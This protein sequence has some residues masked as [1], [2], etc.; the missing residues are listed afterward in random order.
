MTV[1]ESIA[2]QATVSQAEALFREARR[3]RRRR[4]L[5]LGITAVLIS[6]S[7]AGMALS[8][9]TTAQSHHAGGPPAASPKRAGNGPR[10]VPA[11]AET[12]ILSVAG[13]GQEFVENFSGVYST[14]NGGRNWRNITPP[15]LA[16][17]PVLLVHVDGVCSFGAERVWLLVSA[18]ADFGIQLVYTWNGG[19]TW[20]LTPS[21][22]D[23]GGLPS[24]LP[25]G[26]AVSPPDFMTAEDGWDLATS[27][28]ARTEELYRTN[29]GGAHWTFV[30]D[31]PVTGSVEFTNSD[32]GWG[33]TE[34]IPND[35]GGVRTPGGALYRT[36]DGGTTW[37]RV[38]LP[39]IGNGNRDPVTYDLPA[40]FSSDV[41]IVAGRL[42]VPG[43]GRE[44]V[45]VDVTYDGGA[46][47]SQ[48]SIPPSAATRGYQQGFFT[49]PFSASSVTDW[50]VF[51]GSVLLTTS[52]GGRTWSVIH[53]KLPAVAP[54][55]DTLYADLGNKI[56]ALAIRRE[57]ES[58]SQY[59]IVTTNGGRT[60]R[61]VSP[62]AASA[63]GPC[64]R[65]SRGRA[66]QGNAR[67]IALLSP[68]GNQRI[69]GRRP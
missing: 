8:N 18:D 16:E 66:V 52:D 38:R 28:R 48:R 23:D 31:T 44:P 57:R 47:W 21:I 53:P 62:Q 17:N 19:T 37:Q 29:D 11:P 7:V 26:A 32:D 43:N 55:V 2:D 68:T 50:S 41:G 60:W 54:T 6:A 35:Q 34:W 24:F 12:Q 15:I 5:V 69:L 33:I 27:G 9:G 58:S 49:V 63:G 1:I 10:V 46:S 64:I 45:V 61:A 3:R 39:A 36:V 51:E 59:L 13:P 22:S 30:S 40:F 4:R 56:W 42:D 20:N 25:D 65:Q 67:A 14:V